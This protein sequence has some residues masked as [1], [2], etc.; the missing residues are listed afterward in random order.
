MQYSSG[1]ETAELAQNLL[2]CLLA[3]LRGAALKCG[4]ILRGTVFF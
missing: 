3:E 2:L 4:G 1:L